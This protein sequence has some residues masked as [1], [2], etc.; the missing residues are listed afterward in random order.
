MIFFSK[1]IRK[2]K[3]NEKSKSNNKTVNSTINYDND[4]DKSYLKKSKVSNIKQNL[5]NSVASRNRKNN[6]SK[7]EYS[8]Y[9]E[10]NNG[11]LNSTTEI[12]NNNQ[13]LTENNSSSNNKS[14][15]KNVNNK[16]IEESK[17]GYKVYLKKK[18]RKI[19]H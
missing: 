15:D 16:Q 2:T 12:E 10:Q 14:S 7:I 11:G 4:N 13:F 8:M 6:E 18:L 3:G 9:V 17:N 1:E 5:N 19:Q